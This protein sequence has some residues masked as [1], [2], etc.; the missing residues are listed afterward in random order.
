M[1]A[2]ATGIEP[3]PFPLRPGRLGHLPR[4]PHRLRPSLYPPLRLLSL[5][6][7]LCAP[8]HRFGHLAPSC[9]HISVASSPFVDRSRIQAPRTVVSSPTRPIRSYRCRYRATGHS[10]CTPSKGLVV[11]SGFGTLWRFW[12]VFVTTLWICASHRRFR[13]VLLALLSLPTAR[14]TPTS[15]SA[16]A[17]P[18][19]P[20]ALALGHSY[21]R[22]H[23]SPSLHKHHLSSIS[24]PSTSILPVPFVRLRSVDTPLHIPSSIILPRRH[25]ASQH[26]FLR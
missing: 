5:Y 11:W 21:S 16:S 10:S 18:H 2:C 24:P 17:A 15:R 6:P 19:T 9:P 7:S 3:R 8:T 20:S 23:H 4:V 14:K 25:I 13:C 12:G 1:T 22:E 26:R